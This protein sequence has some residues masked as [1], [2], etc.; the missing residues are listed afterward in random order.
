[1]RLNLLFHFLI[2]TQLL[3]AQTFTEVTGTP[4]V[5]VARSSV[6]FA[7]VDGDG[8]NDLMIVGDHSIDEPSA[9][10]YIND[11]GSFTELIGTPFVG[12]SKGS[13]AFSDVDSDGDNDLMIS[14]YIEDTHQFGIYIS[15]ITKLYTNDGGSFTEVTGTPFVGVTGNDGS[16]AFSDVDGDGDNDLLITGRNRVGERIAKLYTNDGSFTSTDHVNNVFE[17]D[18]TTYPNPT[19][20]NTLN[21]IYDSRA[22][23]MVNISLYD[24]NGRLLSKQQKSSEIGE[25]TFSIDIA[26]LPQ[27][28]YIIQLDDGKRK[29]VAKFMV[30]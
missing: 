5:G 22:Y 28:K 2:L 19:N 24:Q 9:K 17:F 20:S 13:V 29:G 3:S 6:A 15:S 26:S 18:F 14:G 4:F 27:G 1:M 7:D 16:L 25:Q 21:I 11:G 10:L 8:D 12:V 23:R 30:Q